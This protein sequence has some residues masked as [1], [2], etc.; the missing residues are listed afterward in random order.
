MVGRVVV[1]KAI[2]SILDGGEEGE[3]RRRRR[4]RE[5]MEKASTTVQEGGLLYD[6]L[7]DF[8]KYFLRVNRE[9]VRFVP[10]SFKG[11]I[12]RS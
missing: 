12:G 7:F 2:G 9:I 4:A 6:N 1:E 5:L 8:I 10:Y 3:E 11:E